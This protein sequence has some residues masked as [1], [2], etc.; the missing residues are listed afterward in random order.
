MS[1]RLD[2]GIA[3]LTEV[4]EE[5]GDLTSTGPLDTA[6]HIKPESRDI[7]IPLDQHPEDHW[8]ANVQSTR[9]SDPVKRC[10]MC[11]DDRNTSEESS[12]E[13]IR[14]HSPCKTMVTD[15]KN[16]LNMNGK[17]EEEKEQE[18][19]GK[20]SGECCVRLKRTLVTVG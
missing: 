5:R 8:L 16:S 3:F 10:N 7:R 2:T 18:E 4:S 19:K 17:V 11:M 13:K 14:V 12:R 9:L 15:C 20:S 1:K 6:D